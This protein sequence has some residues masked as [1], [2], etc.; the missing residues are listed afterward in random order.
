MQYNT[1]QYN[2][3]QYN[4]IQHNT[5]QY[6]TIQHN[7]I[8]Y[9]TILLPP[10]VSFLFSPLL[11]SPL[12][13]TI[14]LFSI[15]YS[16]YFCVQYALRLNPCFSLLFLSL[17][18]S[19]YSVNVLPLLSSPLIYLTSTNFPSSSVILHYHRTLSLLPY[20]FLFQI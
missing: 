18:F 1:I 5:I 20:L 8:L 15:Y 2:T 6:M 17:I 9:N 16:E 11:S 7:T 10:L 3:I 4:T 14:I 19:R 12:I 13:Y